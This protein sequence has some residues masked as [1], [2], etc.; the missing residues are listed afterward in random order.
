MLLNLKLG[1]RLNLIMSFRCV[2]VNFI[3]AVDHNQCVVFMFFHNLRGW[4]SFRSNQISCQNVL[5]LI[6]LNSTQSLFFQIEL[7]LCKY[8]YIYFFFSSKN[9]QVF[10]PVY[11]FST[12]QYPLVFS[13]VF[14][15]F[16]F[17]WIRLNHECLLY[18]S[19]LCIGNIKWWLFESQNQ[20]NFSYKS[21]ISASM[22]Y[23]HLM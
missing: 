4:H 1:F 11:A 14:F 13:T 16:R 17:L 6:F 12:Y 23:L 7:S 21:K 3:A 18:V 22:V 8:H 2:R 20:V 19:L 5:M 15:Q 9:C 10:I